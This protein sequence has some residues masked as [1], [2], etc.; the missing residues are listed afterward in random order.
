MFYQ[1]TFCSK[2]FI[3]KTEADKHI[4][5]HV[6]RLRKQAKVGKAQRAEQKRIDEERKKLE[7]EAQKKRKEEIAKHN[8]AILEHKKEH[9]YIMRNCEKCS[10]LLRIY[11]G[12][13]RYY[14]P[15]A[16]AYYGSSM[17]TY[18]NPSSYDGAGGAGENS[19]STDTL[20]KML[21]S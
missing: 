1:C 6:L 14:N 12:Y 3:V 4:Q 2:M 20:D 5:G 11:Q 10:S 16:P 19:I 9:K 18:Y 7:I 15:W 17:S 13:N 21:I 8:K